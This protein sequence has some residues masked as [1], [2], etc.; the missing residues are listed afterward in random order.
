MKTM[1]YSLALTALLLPLGSCSDDDSP[2]LTQKDWDGTATYFASTDEMTFATYYKPYVGYVG[3]PMP[4]YDPV[5][6][7]FKV[8]YLQDFRPN[9]ET[10]HPIWGVSTKDA[11]S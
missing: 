5:A 1:I 8:L 10:Y 6:Q 11:A 3:D 9:P 4:F 2:V 7:D